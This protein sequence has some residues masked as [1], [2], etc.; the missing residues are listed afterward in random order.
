MRFAENACRFWLTPISHIYPSHQLDGHVVDAPGLVARVGTHC[1]ARV[2]RKVEGRAAVR[3]GSLHLHGKAVGGVSPTRIDTIL[4][5]HPLQEARAPIVRLRPHWLAMNQ[6]R[7]RVTFPLVDE[8]Y[9][10]ADADSC[11]RWQRI[12]PLGSRSC[13]ATM[14]SEK[15]VVGATAETP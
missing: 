7:D 6:Q 8:M 14:P 2:E 3:K 11:V 13:E 12:R 4:L 15:M 5:T 9:P 10:C 1:Q